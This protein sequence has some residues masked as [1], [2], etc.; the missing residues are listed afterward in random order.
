MGR[1]VANRQEKNRD[2]QRFKVFAFQKLL[3][4]HGL[5][6]ITDAATHEYS[7]NIRV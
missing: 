5:G 3:S 4:N 7:R 1:N 6:L 2:T